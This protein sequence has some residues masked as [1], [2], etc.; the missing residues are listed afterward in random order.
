MRPKILLWS[1]DMKIDGV[2]MTYHSGLLPRTPTDS[3]YVCLNIPIVNTPT[4]RSKII[5]ES[6]I[7]QIPE[8]IKTTMQVLFLEN[9]NLETDSLELID[10][11]F[12]LLH[13]TNAPTKYNASLEEILNFASKGTEIALELLNDDRTKNKI[14]STDKNL[15]ETILRLIN[16]RLTTQIEKKQGLHF[17]CNSMALFGCEEYVQSSANTNTFNNPNNPLLKRLY[18]VEEFP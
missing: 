16:Q 11:E 15:S 7:K 4:F 1:K 5:S 8:E 10:Y 17:V 12:E 18:A 13:I 9:L 3:L 2:V 14:W 6:T